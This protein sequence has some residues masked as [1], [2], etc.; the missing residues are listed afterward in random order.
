VLDA[1]HLTSVFEI[2]S[3]EQALSILR[4]PEPPPCYAVAWIGFRRRLWSR[5]RCFI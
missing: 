4:A 2:S 1:T 3:L 5:A